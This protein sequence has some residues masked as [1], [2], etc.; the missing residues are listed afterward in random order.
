MQKQRP[1]VSNFDH[2][3]LHQVYLVAGLGRI[4]LVTLLIVGTDCIGRCKFDHHIIKAMT[5]AV[6][7]ST[8][9][10]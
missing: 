3:M 10:Q 4:K 1:L 9:Y 5:A 8:I 7:T 2:I 6:H